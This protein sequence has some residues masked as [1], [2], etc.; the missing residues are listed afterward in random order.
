MNIGVKSGGPY[1]HAEKSHFCNASMSADALA[2]EFQSYFWQ[3][4]LFAFFSKLNVENKHFEDARELLVK[5]IPLIENGLAHL[6]SPFIKQLCATLST[7][8]TN[9]ENRHAF[10]STQVA[11][12]SYSSLLRERKNV[13]CAAITITHNEKIMLPRWASYYSR[14]VRTIYDHAKNDPHPPGSPYMC[15]PP[16][17][18]DGIS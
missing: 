17:L 18:S 1:L 7:W 12:A 14:Q 13:S 3:E 11:T 15:S 5:V 8:A 2:A 9:W 6:Q 10:M 4:E 16:F